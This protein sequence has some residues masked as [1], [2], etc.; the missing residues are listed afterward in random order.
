MGLEDEKQKGKYSTPKELEPRTCPGSHGSSPPL[1]MPHTPHTR[2]RGLLVSYMDDSRA[3]ATLTGDGYHTLR[4]I[5]KGERSQW[6]SHHWLLLEGGPL[7]RQLFW[8]ICAE[9]QAPVRRCSGMKVGMGKGNALMEE[10]SKELGS[11]SQ[12]RNIEGPP[13]ELERAGKPCP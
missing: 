8:W 2:L 13:G 12:N 10:D 1:S 11:R 9:R 7:L 5:G 3:E 6:T 4:L